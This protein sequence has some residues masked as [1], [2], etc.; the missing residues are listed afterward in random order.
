MA[1]DQD[2]E[3]DEV[4]AE[5][6]NLI[7][8]IRER[9]KAHQ[10]TPYRKA[11]LDRIRRAKLGQPV[12]P[13]S[14]LPGGGYITYQLLFGKHSHIDKADLERS[15]KNYQEKVE[16]AKKLNLRAPDPF[17]PVAVEF[18][19]K[20]N[21][22]VVPQDDME[23]L[24]LDQDPNKFRPLTGA[25]H[26][27]TATIDDLMAEVER[28]KGENARKDQELAEARKSQSGKGK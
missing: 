1:Q 19:P 8:R 6:L 2:L 28:L 4:T 5:E 24:A 9:S 13:P 12:G 21:N 20:G 7:R 14:E 18:H 3:L 17:S 27:S 22:T 15:R 11:L 10:H 23:A 26:Q 25:G 16:E